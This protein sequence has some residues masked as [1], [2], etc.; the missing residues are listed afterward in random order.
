MLRQ[1]YGR[2]D[3]RALLLASSAAILYGVYRARSTRV[4]HAAPHE[5]APRAGLQTPTE[6]MSASSVAKSA[7]LGRAAEA[8]ATP[9]EAVAS[10]SARLADY[11][12]SERRALIARN[13]E[14]RDAAEKTSDAMSVVASLELA[15]AEHA[16]E[17][18]AQLPPQG[19]S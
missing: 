2:S 12:S 18:A 4:A 11:A 7:A 16:A 3:G 15:A 6:K 10:D 1:L 9:S 17:A 19:L 14:P 5:L 13:S 8:D